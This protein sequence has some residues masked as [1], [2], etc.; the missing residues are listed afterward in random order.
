MGAPARKPES[1]IT[2]VFIAPETLAPVLT[3]KQLD[4]V[5]M[6]WNKCAMAFIQT[7]T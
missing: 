6:V 1:G 3:Q 5:Q 7:D 4:P 2:V